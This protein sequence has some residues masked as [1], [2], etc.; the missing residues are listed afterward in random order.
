MATNKFKDVLL[1]FIQNIEYAYYQLQILHSILHSLVESW[2]QQ[3]HLRNA[4]AVNWGVQDFEHGVEI[5]SKHC[6]L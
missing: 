1:F 3:H 5:I 4:A 2:G 6:S